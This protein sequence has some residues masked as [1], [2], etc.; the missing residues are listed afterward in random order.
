MQSKVVVCPPA[1][2]LAHLRTAYKGK[3]IMFGVQDISLAPQ[4]A[5]TGEVTAEL[6]RASGAEFAIVGHA[7]RRAEGEDNATVAADARAALDAGLTPI[8]CVGEVERDQGGAYFSA[9]ES[10][11][12]ASIARVLGT[13]LGKVVIAY[14]PVWAIGAPVAPGPRTIAEAVLYIRKTLAGQ[15]GRDAAL[16]VRVLYGGAVDHTSASEILERGQANGFLVGR[17]SVST[18]E[19]I[20][21]I[22][23]CESSLSSQS[24]TRSSATPSSSARP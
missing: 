11:L 8:V 4:G 10:Q 7:E 6:A 20:G 19:F 13:E 18:P 21:I 1:L 17:A 23:A 12:M 22:R 2:L 9:I 5:H 24:G 3:R 15:F 16:K 14:E